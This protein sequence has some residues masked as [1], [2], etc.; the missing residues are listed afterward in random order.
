MKKWIGLIGIVVVAGCT[1]VTEKALPDK[2]VKALTIKPVKSER[3]TSIDPNTLYLLLAGELAGQR[4]KYDV[5]L[6]AYLQAAKR[7][8]D[9]R[10]VERAAR[11][12]L[13]LRDPQRTQEAVELWLKQD[14][15]NLT[16]RKIALLS[17]IQNAD[18]TA[19]LEQLNAYLALDPAGFESVLL[20]MAKVMMRNGR[21]QQMVEIL[22]ELAKQHPEQASIYYVQALLSSKEKKHDVALEQI[23]QALVIEP[24]WKKALI[25]RAQIAVRAGFLDRAEQY[26]QDAIE[27]Y[28][29]D[30]KFK[31]MLA[32]VYMQAK[33]FDQ[34]LEGYQDILD[35]KPDDAESQFAMALIYLQQEELDDA[36]KIFKKLSYKPAWQAQSA[37]YL[38]QIALRQDKSDDALVWF[39]SISSGP[40]LYDAKVA[41]ISLLM[42]QKQY[43]AVAKRLDQ[44]EQKFPSKKLTVWLLR[45]ELYNATGQ[46]QKAYDLLTK[47]LEQYPDN[48]DLLY[49]RALIA[50]QLGKLDVLERDLLKILRQYPNDAMALNALGYTLAEKTQR[51]DEAQKYLE[52]ALSIK[53]DSGVII[54]SYGW[55]KYK[56]GD[57]A[58]ALKLIRQAYQLQPETEIA[59]HLA[60][61]LWKQGEYDEARA[62]YEQA[63]R[64]HPND[65]YLLRFKKDFLDAAE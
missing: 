29:D 15:D 35:Q 53:P 44:L 9:P 14:P 65:K 61:I 56:Q 36:E 39:D 50:E 16:A 49:T 42:S 52:K 1:T 28:P 19:V 12:A 17:A 3:Q 59:A 55:L 21:E 27:Q 64:K 25:L 31:K 57:L 10:V 46:L 58:Q 47:G 48:K 33:Q 4:K 26:L 11:I 40:Y 18:K 51:Y 38:G 5:A 30:L 24:G 54:D 2:E 34:A 22:Q 37:Y 20:D 23:N 62:V 6:D 13:Y 32:Q 41:A 63:I 45:S 43:N 8:D 7:V 60:E